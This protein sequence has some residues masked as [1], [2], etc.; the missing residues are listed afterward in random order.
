MEASVKLHNKIRNVT[1]SPSYSAIKTYIRCACAEIFLSFGANIEKTLPVVM[2]LL[3]KSCEDFWLAKDIHKAKECTSRIAE[4]WMR[5][6]NQ[7]MLFM[8]DQLPPIEVQDMKLAVFHALLIDLQ[9]I[10]DTSAEQL[11]KSAI[12]VVSRSVELTFDLLSVLAAREKA[13]VVEIY[14]LFANRCTSIPE[15]NTYASSLYEKAIKILDTAA[16][17]EQENTPIRSNAAA[18]DNIQRQIGVLKFRALISLAYLSIGE[19]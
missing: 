12:E 5:C 14:L 7:K 2:K 4:I 13:R 1:I 15:F 17:L 9:I 8:V 18:D 19:G 10:M 11:D 3:K 6:K 16:H